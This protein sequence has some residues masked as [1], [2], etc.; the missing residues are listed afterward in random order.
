MPRKILIAIFAGAM[1][2]CLSRC[3]TTENQSAYVRN[4]VSYGV[5]KGLFQ[6]R[7]WHYYERAVSFE[8]G[9]FWKEAE[10]DLREAL[11][12]R[13]VDQSRA[14]TYGMHFVDFFPHRELG[15]TLYH[16]NRIE[17]AIAELETS[18]SGETS[19][20]AQFYLD[21]AR[22]AWIETIRS[23][24]RPPEIS[25]AS[26]KEK[27]ATNRFDFIVEGV[28]TDDTFVRNIR[29]NNRPVRIDLSAPRIAFE[30]EVPLRLGNN[31][32]IIEATDLAGKTTRTTRKIFC[33]RAGPI[34]NLDDLAAVSAGNN[35]Y[36]IRGCAHDTSSIRRIE[37]NGRSVMTQPAEEADIDHIATL[38]P[39]TKTVVVIAEDRLGNKTRAELSPKRSTA[40]VSESM[41][42]ASLD[43]NLPLFA[44][45]GVAE[46]KTTRDGAVASTPASGLKKKKPG[47]GVNYALIVGV[48]AYMEWAPLETAV[49]DARAFG[50]ILINRYGY[51]PENVTMLLDENVSRE[52]FLKI[53]MDLTAGLGDSDNLLVYYAGHGQLSDQTNDGYWIPVEGKRGR[54]EFSWVAH[55]AVKNMVISEEV[56]GKNIMIITDSCYGGKLLRGGGGEVTPPGDAHLARLAELSSKKSRQ[57]ISSGSI[58]QVADWGRDGHSL[59]A[60]YLLKALEENSRPLIDLKTLINTKVWEPVF[61]ISGQRPTVGRLKTPMDED[62]EFILALGGAEPGPIPKNSGPTVKRVLKVRGQSS[63]LPPAGGD[64]EAPEISMEKWKDNQAVFLDQIYL[65]GKISDDNEVREVAVNGK[66]LLKKPGKNIYFQHLQ[67]L[68]EGENPFIIETSDADGNRNR[69]QLTI[70]RKTQK[71]Y[72]DGARM[73]AVLFP[74]QI[75]GK[76][77]MDLGG[78][79]LDYL[80]DSERFDLKEWDP[81]M[82]LGNKAPNDQVISDTAR[83][84]KADFDFPDFPWRACTIRK[85]TVLK[86]IRIMITPN[87]RLLFWFAMIAFPF[88]LLAASMPGRAIPSYCAIGGFVVLAVVDALLAMR[89]KTD[90]SVLLP[91]I[92]RLSKGREDK[93]DVRIETPESFRGKIRIGLPFPPEIGTPFR[94]V[95]ARISPGASVQTVRWPCTG[96][97]QGLYPIDKCRLQTDSPLGFWGRRHEAETRSEIRVYPNFMSGKNK[98][99]AMIMFNRAGAHSMRQLG[100]GRDFEQLREYTPGDRFEDICWKA[101]ARRGFPISK[102]FQIERTREV[103][104]VIDFSRLSARAADGR[105]PGNG[106][107]G[108]ETILDKFI[109]ASLLAGMAAQSLG[110]M[111]GV[112]TFADRVDGFIRAKSGK[113]HYDS[114]RDMLYTLQPKNVTPDFSELFTFVGV[115]LRKRA[116]LIFLTNLDDPVLSREF[117]RGA[118]IIGK[119]HLVM[120]DMVKPPGSDPLFSDPDAGSLNDIHEKLSGHFVWKCL[121]ETEKILKRRGVGFLLLNHETMYT[122]LVSQYMNVKQRQI[123]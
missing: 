117:I 87:N 115:R 35:R 32:I 97:R 25:I 92:V 58:E 52:M 19:A 106:E 73:T 54:G 29:V 16:Q 120:V 83:K 77:D 47:K 116:L 85:N 30:A 45:S 55:T 69:E 41:L 80:H 109:S 59:F 94:D 26:P 33:D 49:N 108:G 9:K 11:K 104:L 107:N 67:E 102:I 110:D 42:L 90:I 22:K 13:D 114:C 31:K 93:I 37:I 7:W 101:T 27:A 17:E 78:A 68:K 98:L 113:A 118:H 28:A 105:N 96:I 18:L 121:F 71:I 95:C 57:I 46:Q 89:K 56:R 82:A 4:G 23:D 5:T 66:S 74:L 119:R 81:G 8:D 86:S 1:A 79:L 48:N 38:S 12:Q 61:N 60:Y 75:D 21:K 24:T 122:D 40:G 112:L 70:R 53:F 2:F 51:K 111:F 64:K 14:R 50:E 6:H 15:V 123:L 44:Q 10:A 20:K 99:T 63:A 103:Y 84:L 39:E 62:G 43:S 65:S 88:S 3:K 76:T 100:K 91:E 72:E 36:R 34:L